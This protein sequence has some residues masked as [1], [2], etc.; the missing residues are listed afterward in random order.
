[1]FG[2]DAQS[3]SEGPSNERKGTKVMKPN[4]SQ[5][6]RGLVH[7]INTEKARTPKQSTN[8]IYYIRTS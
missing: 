1:V 4:A 5:G 6:W 8:S 3:T 7:A 2:S